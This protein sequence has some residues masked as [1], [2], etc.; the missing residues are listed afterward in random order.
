MAVW[1]FG[2]NEYILMMLHEG[3]NKRTMNTLDSRHSSPDMAVMTKKSFSSYRGKRWRGIKKSIIALSFIGPA[4][5]LYVLFMLYPMM[6]AVR[7][8]F[9]DWNGSS[10]TMN[11]IGIRNYTELSKDT[12]FIKS[13]INNLY[14]VVL[15]LVMMILP[16]LVLSILISKVKRGR[17]FFRTAFFL[18]SVLSLTVVGV[19]W[20][21]IYDPSY[22]PLNIML[23]MF[24][25][26]SLT[27]NW[28][29][30]GHT[31]IP[32]LVAASTWSFYGFYMVLFLAGLQ[33]I[34]QTIYEAAEID[35]AGSVRK[36]WNITLPSLRNTMNVVIS[37]DVIYS[38]KGFAVVWIM[39]QG[40]PFYMSEVVAS[41]VY[42]AAF[43]LNK[44]SY[45]VAGSVVLGIIV[46]VLTLAF[47]FIRDRRE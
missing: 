14:W 23:R 19:L 42:K 3:G 10:P 22:G 18:P 24:G 46:I 47:N 39:T 16:T 41:Y 38:L 27:H 43:S 9:F 36:F 29:G 37:M 20:N 25:L 1:S 15:S 13:L 12:I 2:L 5:V 33:N 17:T 21:K 44:V 28:L 34:D 45:A 26:D 32:S 31:V 4:L 8:S 7:L 35:G 11:Y 30:E 6:D 40:G